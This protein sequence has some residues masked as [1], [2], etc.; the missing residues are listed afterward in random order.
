MSDLSSFAICECVWFFPH[1]EFCVALMPG[2]FDRPKSRL[3]G[4]LK[5]SCR[6]LSRLAFCGCVS[7]ILIKLKRKSSIDRN[8]LCMWDLTLHADLLRIA[9]SSS[10]LFLVLS[11]SWFLH[12][13]FKENNQVSCQG[14]RINQSELW[15]GDSIL[16]AWF[17]LVIV[18]WMRL[19]LLHP[20]STSWFVFGILNFEEK[21]VAFMPGK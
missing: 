17:L 5:S 13:D 8:H 3:N 6:V 18:L 21:K 12:F 19:V 10:S 1:R 15:I 7:Y 4:E 20:N 11:T 2:H 9:S 14:N 16:Y